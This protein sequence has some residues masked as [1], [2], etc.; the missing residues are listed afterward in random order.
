M[1]LKTQELPA[2]NSSEDS[3]SEE[4]EEDDVA[5]VV[6]GSIDRHLQLG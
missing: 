1:K 4:E 5:V 2:D 6:E 3:E